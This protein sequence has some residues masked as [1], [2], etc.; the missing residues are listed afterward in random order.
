[1]IAIYYLSNT[2]FIKKVTLRNA[3]ALPIHSAIN[4]T[5]FVKIKQPEN[6]DDKILKILWDNLKKQAIIDSEI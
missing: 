5:I 2:K 1:M 6:Q 4:L 3:N